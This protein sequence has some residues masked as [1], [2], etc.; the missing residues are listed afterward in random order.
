MVADFSGHSLPSQDRVGFF[1]FARRTAFTGLGAQGPNQE[2]PM[3]IRPIAISAAFAIGF[4]T[5]PLSTAE[6]QSNTPQ[7]YSPQYYPVCSPFPL[8]WPFCVAGAVLDIAATIVTTPIRLLTGAPP[9]GYYGAPY[10][11]PPYPPPPYYAPGYYAP[12]N[13]SGPR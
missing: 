9:F 7:Y 8:E 11:P 3:R 4:A 5:L 12:P 6:A 13:S 2:P 10:A 1:S